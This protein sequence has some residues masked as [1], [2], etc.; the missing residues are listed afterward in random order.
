M[1]VNS[2]LLIEV[3]EVS[4]LRDTVYFHVA[5]TLCNDIYLYIVR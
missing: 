1:I 2:S 4:V 5:K 3:I